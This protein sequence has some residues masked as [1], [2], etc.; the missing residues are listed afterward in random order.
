MHICNYF[1]HK[2][3]DN[4]NNWSEL[5]VHFNLSNFIC[6]FHLQTDS[7][8]VTEITFTAEQMLIANKVKYGEAGDSLFTK[9]CAL[10]LW[11][12]ATLAERSVTGRK[13]NSKKDSTAKPPLTP[14]KVSLIKG[15][16]QNKEFLTF[17]L[18]YHLTLINILSLM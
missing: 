6:I 16:Y 12:S 14:E 18:S 17:Y 2:I 8:S 5:H 7:N 13:C 4:E 9:K 1:N 3:F 15:M 11:G 10:Q